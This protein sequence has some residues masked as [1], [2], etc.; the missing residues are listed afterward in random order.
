MVKGYPQSSLPKD[1]IYIFFFQF[2]NF[3]DHYLH[4]SDFIIAFLYPQI[5]T[6][7]SDVG[8]NQDH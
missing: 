2:M 1:S 6:G 7:T 4:L 3:D 5:L 8:I